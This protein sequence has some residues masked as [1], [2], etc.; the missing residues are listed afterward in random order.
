MGTQR[1]GTLREPRLTADDIRHY[2]FPRRLGRVD[3]DDVRRFQQRVADEVE[4]LT[5]ERHNAQQFPVA[6]VAA[7]EAT[8]ILMH[9]R[10][11]GETVVRQGQDQARGMVSEAQALCERMIA[12]GHAR[13]QEMINS[14]RDQ[15]QA[16]VAEAAARFPADAQAQIAYLDTFTE[17]L[18]AHLRTAAASLERRRPPNRPGHPPQG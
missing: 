9:A 6:D 5:R 13:Q 10:R 16:I 12:D 14:A 18:V 3:P 2:D 4:L 7:R 15:A 1:T 8:H 17:V 11:T